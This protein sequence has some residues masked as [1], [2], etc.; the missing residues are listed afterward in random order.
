MYAEEAGRVI[1]Q[2]D[3]SQPLFLMV[4]FQAPHN[5]FSQPPDRY[6]LPYANDTELRRSRRAATVTALDSAVGEVVAS[7]RAAGILDSTFLLFSSDNGGAGARNNAPLRGA[8]ETMYEGGMR[9]VSVVRGPGL[10]AGRAWPG[11]AHATDW[12]VTLL[13]L[14]GLGAR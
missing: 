5:P 9:V 13:T 12:F 11:L 10:P 3:P 6:F 7:L 4:A 8:K 14:A 1:A 2:H